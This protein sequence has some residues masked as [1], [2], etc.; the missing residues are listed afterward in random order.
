[1][2]YTFYIISHDRHRDDIIYLFKG[3]FGEAKA[4]AQKALKKMRDFD[5]EEYER[6]NNNSYYASMIEGD[7]SV[8]VGI[9]NIITS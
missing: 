2:K 1:M 4:I 7:Y 3:T 8:T 6:E 9:P 5:I